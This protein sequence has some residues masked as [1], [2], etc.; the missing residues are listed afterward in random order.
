MGVLPSGIRIVP[1]S[2]LITAKL[3]VMQLGA[4]G[5]TYVKPFMIKVVMATIMLIVAVSRALVVPVYLAQL[6]FLSLAPAS[7]RLLER[8]S[9]GFMVLGLAAG[10]CIIVGAMVRGY[11]QA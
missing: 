8:T 9:F 2:T 11:R 5:T 10:A 6:G 4:I 7:A 1:T 3:R